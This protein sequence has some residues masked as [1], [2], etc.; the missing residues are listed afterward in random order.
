MYDSVKKTYPAARK[1]GNPLQENE[2]TPGKFRESFRTGGKEK[3]L[4]SL[5][6]NYYTA[7]IYHSYR[8]G[9]KILQDGYLLK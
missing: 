2:M 3:I 9:Y 5:R 4:F 1:E 7:P 6:F 8:S